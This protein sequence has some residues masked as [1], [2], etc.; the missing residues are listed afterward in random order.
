MYF[1]NVLLRIFF[2]FVEI[3]IV[4]SFRELLNSPRSTWQDVID[5]LQGAIQHLTW[6]ESEHIESLRKTKNSCLTLIIR[7]FELSQ[8]HP[9]KIKDILLQCVINGNSLNVLQEAISI[10]PP[11]FSIPPTDVIIDV[12]SLIQKNLR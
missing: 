5:Y 7:K 6:M 10:C 11:E 3:I 8:S 4:N 9:D 2:L 1:L 12:L